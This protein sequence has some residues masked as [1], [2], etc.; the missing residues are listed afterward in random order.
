[1]DSLRKIP[2]GIYEK[3]FPA[4]YSL[5][6][7]LTT[8]REIG[9]D[10]VELSIDESPGRLARLN[11]SKAERTEIRQMIFQ[12]GMPVYAMGVSAHRKYPL[13]SLSPELAQRG[14]TILDQS[15][16]LASDLGVRV[17]QLM[18]YDVFYEPSTTETQENYLMGLRAGVQWASAAGVMLALENVDHE[19]VDSI[20]KAM[21]FVNE[22]DSPWFEIYP[23]IGNL[24][25]FG[26]DPIQ[27]LPL[28]NGHL[29]GVHVKDT[30]PGEVRGV[31]LE[32]G[33]VP[34]PKVFNLLSQ[35]GYTGP[36]VMEMWA[37]L[38][39]TGDPVDSAAQALA[40]LDRWIEGAWGKKPRIHKDI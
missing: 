36:V 35:M 5:E 3:A 1:M 30:L 16:Q 26:Y 2:V 37:H 33:I 15:I 13:G 19:L 6:H 23:D 22:I 27:Q 40:T 9:Y 18:G 25:A 39:Q 24:A 31:M 32:K 29:V 4:D 38:D 14:L 12:T 17:I 7:I 8:A 28:A 10:F 11:W 20:D 21:R 34:F